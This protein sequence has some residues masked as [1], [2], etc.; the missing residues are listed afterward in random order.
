M[1]MQSLRLNDVKVVL[2]DAKLQ[3]RNSL[4][5]ALL[6]QGLRNIR[7]GSEVRTISESLHD[8]Y[9]PDI[10]ICDT[11]TRGGDV[12]DL[13]SQ[14]RHVDVGRNPFLCVIAIT[15]DRS[16]RHIQRVLDTG[17]DFIVAA[18]F[19]PQTIID[20]ISTLVYSRKPFVVTDRYL[21]PDRRDSPRDEP[22]LPLMDVPNSLK[23][24][25]FG[26][27]KFKNHLKQIRSALMEVDGR[28]LQSSAVM[29]AYKVANI[30]RDCARYPAAVDTNQLTNV[31]SSALGLQQRAEDLREHHVS[32]LCG[33]VNTVVLAL[34]ESAGKPQQRDI[35]LLNQLSLALRAAY[36]TERGTRMYAHDI[37]QA[38]TT[39]H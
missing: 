12:P 35:Q 7:D 36:R 18:P 13:I 28:K 5:M 29:L 4:R 8:S 20:R 14:I 38:V 27:F 11:S 32:E 19:S 9:G 23:D 1:T 17:A 3:V 15:W 39:A 24:K 37:A 30:A 16:E 2:A 10:L 34:V 25:A 21:G 31:A 26:E 33:A 22:S 6:D